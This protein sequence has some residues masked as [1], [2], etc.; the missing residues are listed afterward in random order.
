MQ[1]G[2]PSV[3]VSD[4]TLTGHRPAPTSDARAGADSSRAAG[5]S[6]AVPPEMNGYIPASDRRRLDDIGTAAVAAAAVRQSPS[7][8]HPGPPAQRT[9][10]K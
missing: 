9:K 4:L 5:P 1:T 8:S 3:G 10:L 6:A 2:Y 7:N